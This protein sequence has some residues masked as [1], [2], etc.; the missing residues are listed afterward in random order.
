MKGKE[1]RRIVAIGGAGA[2]AGT[3]SEYTV[4]AGDSLGKIAQSFGM[5]G[6]ALAELNGL[7]NPNMIVVGQK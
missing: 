1:V 6:K 4:V 7:T 5:T 3:A 2:S